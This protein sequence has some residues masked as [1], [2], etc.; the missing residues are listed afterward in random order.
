MP[1]KQKRLYQ[2]IVNLTITLIKQKENGRITLRKLENKFPYLSI[3]LHD[4]CVINE[5]NIEE[6]KT[7][8]DIISMLRSWDITENGK[9]EV[10]KSLI[11]K[12]ADEDRK[13][14]LWSGH[15]KI[16]DALTE[17]FK[18]FNPYKLHGRV[19][20]DK[21]ESVSE[22]NAAICNAFIKDDKSNLLIANY[23]CLSSAVNLVEVTRMIFWDRSWRSDI[24][25]QALKRAN[26]IGSIEPL[27][28]NMLIFFSSIEEY[29]DKE[30]IKRTNFNNNLWEGGKG[31]KDVLDDRDIL[32]LDDCREIL[33]GTMYA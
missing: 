13:I 18:D 31:A 17:K 4:P 2:A 22:R 3:A 1:P 7:S 8:P 27:I 24:F 9:Y 23:D 12:Y 29:Q 11:E 19:T 32:T 15:P 6:S 25:N 33:A 5:G 21:G 10:A 26:R 16:I 28:V 20:V 14:I 30:I